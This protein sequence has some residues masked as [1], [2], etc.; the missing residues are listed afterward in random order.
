M[1]GQREFEI[2]LQLLQRVVASRGKDPSQLASEYV[3][4]A[5][6]AEDAMAPR[7]AVSLAPLLTGGNQEGVATP[8]ALASGVVPMPAGLV[9]PKT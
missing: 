5:T 2:C 7:A 9:P 1:N 3:W 6:T 4:P 8:G